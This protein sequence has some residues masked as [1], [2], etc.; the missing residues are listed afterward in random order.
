MLKSLLH[1]IDVAHRDLAMISQVAD[2]CFQLKPLCSNFICI[3]V[4]PF[5]EL[6]ELVQHDVD[7]I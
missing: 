1:A 2:V 4:V 6:G 5:E 7:L 3:N